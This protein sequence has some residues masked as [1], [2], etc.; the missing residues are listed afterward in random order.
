[1]FPDIE[2]PSQLAQLSARSCFRSCRH[3]AFPY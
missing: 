3:N 1:M 2:K